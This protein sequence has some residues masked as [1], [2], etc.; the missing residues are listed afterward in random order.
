MIQQIATPHP[1]NAK[2]YTSTMSVP[3]S[4]PTTSNAIVQRMPKTTSVI[5]LL[6]LGLCGPG[7]R[8]AVEDL[9]HGRDQRDVRRV[10]AAV[11]EVESIVEVRRIEPLIVLHDRLELVEAL[12]EPGF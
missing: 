2:T 3:A 12:R 4:L 9:A 10:F 7:F 8:F 11:A 5:T 6:R 1:P